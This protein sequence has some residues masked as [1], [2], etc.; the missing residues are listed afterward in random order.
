MAVDDDSGQL[1]LQIF[2]F[3]ALSLFGALVARLWYLQGIES[4][5]LQLEAAANV[6]EPV[7]DEA[8]RG[9]IRDRSGRILVDNEVVQVVTIDRAVLETMKSEAMDDMFN[10]L[11]LAI[12]RSGRLTKVVAIEAEVADLGYGPFDEIPIAV[13][14]ESELLVYLGERPDRFPG[15]R[16]VQRTVRS[17]PYGRLAAHLLGY[18]GPITLAEW[19]SANAS[20]DP[21]DDDAKTYQLNDEIGKTGI[22][23]IFESELRGV[24]GVRLLEVDNRGQVIRERAR[25][26]PRAGNDVWLTIDIDLQALAEAELADGLARAREQEP[27][28]DEPDFKAA[29]GSVVAIDPR[30]GDVLTMASFPTYDPAEFVNGISNSEFEALTSPDNYSPILNRVIQGTYAPGSTF[31]PVTAYAALTQGVIGSG[32]RAILSVESGYIDT[33]TYVFSE[34]VEESSTCQFESP[35][36]CERDVDLRMALTVSSDTYFYN[37]GGEGFWLRPKP[38][39]EGIQVAARELGLGTSTGV[40]LPYERG[41]VVPDRDYFDA[42]FDAGVFVRDGS[43]WF[44]GDTIILAIGQ[45]NL[46][47]T[48]IQLVNVYATLANGGTVHQPNIVTKIVKPDG[49]VVREFGPRVLREIDIPAR[50]LDPIR[51][52]LLTVPSTRN[53]SFG[54]A[55]NSFNSPF[56]ANFPLLSWPVAGKTGTAEVDGKADTSLFVAYGPN[57]FPELGIDISGEPEIAIVVV[58]EEAGFGSDSAAPV[59]AKILEPLATDTI[60][61]AR[62]LDE[63]DRDIAAYL[64]TLA[65]AERAAE[66]TAESQ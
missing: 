58:L 50:V 61:R 41:G 46:L 44:G 55:Y 15:V 5:A 25:S 52:G 62:T 28:E 8:P 10:R 21:A 16:V 26:A 53:L 42:Q 39:D 37:I 35:Y 43:Q 48:P 51:D 20:I 22:E 3:V 64:A 17:Y 65:A 23:R 57:D 19:E 9:R 32:G 24:P 56:G 27:E 59:V 7:Y 45:G 11:A 18:V 1:R 14:V 49:E 60:P 33:G 4:E 29:A 31:K 30:N 66:E 12:S 36:C 34:C 63:F 54:T 2:A 13:D 40:Q 38:E 6:L 47:V